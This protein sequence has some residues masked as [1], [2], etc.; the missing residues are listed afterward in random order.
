V[1]LNCDYGHGFSV[2]QVV[3]MVK[4]VSGADFK[5]DIAPRRPGIMF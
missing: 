2:R 3:E 5:V 4:R 1:T